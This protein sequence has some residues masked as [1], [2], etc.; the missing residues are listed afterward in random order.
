ML[1]EIPIFFVARARYAITRIPGSRRKETRAR[2]RELLEWR[3][4]DRPCDG[5][6]PDA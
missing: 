3:H 5:R 2:A 6:S 4:A 1:A